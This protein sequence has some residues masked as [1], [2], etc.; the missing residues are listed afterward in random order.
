[1]VSCPIAT[2]RRAA[3]LRRVVRSWR[4]SLLIAAILLVACDLHWTSP[5]ETTDN[6]IPFIYQET[7]YYCV[8][9]C[10]QM[11]GR[12][13]GLSVPAQQFL[14]QDMNGSTGGGGINGVDAQYIA[15][16]LARYGGIAD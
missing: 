6:G 2:V 16:E 11:S 10:V 15:P 1:M 4:M 13:Y 9:A 5:G 8:P 14:Y 3:M 7:G 12:F